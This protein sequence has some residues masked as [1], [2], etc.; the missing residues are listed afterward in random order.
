MT[1]FWKETPDGV[2]IM[3]KVQP[4][5]RR[6]GVLGVA[7]SAAGPRLRIGVSEAAEA[8]RAN[9]ALI[10]MVA[11]L[12]AVPKAAVSIQVGQA[13]REKLIRVSGR[14]QALSAKLAAL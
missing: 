7:P 4:K 8:G 13:S 6:A 1:A 14:T 10:G 3:V 9:E 11:A 2:T 5:S 12:L